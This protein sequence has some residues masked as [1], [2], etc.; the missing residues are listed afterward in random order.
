RKVTQSYITMFTRN[1]T[2]VSTQEEYPFIKDLLAEHPEELVDEVKAAPQA[3]IEVV[4]QR[5]KVEK[6][7]RYSKLVVVSINDVHGHK[8]WQR[9]SRSIYSTIF[10][11]SW[12]MGSRRMRTRGSSFLRN[13]RF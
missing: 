3:V 2:F 8:T 11:S 9:R 10:I 13:Q 4:I 1:K 6:K 5:K 12:E 7:K